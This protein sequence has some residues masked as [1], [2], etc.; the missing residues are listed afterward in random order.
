MSMRIIAGRHKGRKLE[1]DDGKNIRPTA[2]RTREAVFNILMHNRFTDAELI[3]ADV[4][5][6]CC[7][8][9]AFGLEALSR[10]AARAALVDSN[11]AALKLA[12][13]NTIHL[14]EVANVRLMQADVS[15][16]PHAPFAC[17]IIYLDPPYGQGLCEPALQGLVANGWLKEDAL[18]LVEQQE[19]EPLRLPAGLQLLDTRTY[20]NAKLSILARE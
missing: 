8:T 16:L 5:D 11:T 9:G 2:N 19:R 3:G 12:Q 15:Q 18:V 7:G 4:A 13:K 6:L 10:G 1:A 14:G 20:G 17:D